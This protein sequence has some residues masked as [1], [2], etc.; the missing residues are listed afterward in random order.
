LL[1]NVREPLDINQVISHNVTAARLRAELTQEQLAQRCVERGLVWSRSVIAA[2]EAANRRLN[3][4]ELLIVAMSLDIATS[5]LLESDA[6]HVRIGSDEYPGR[7]IR[8]LLTSRPHMNWRSD[9]KATDVID[10][11]KRIGLGS[12][13]Q[14]AATR[15][16]IESAQVAELSR[17]LFG[18]G[19]GEGRDAQAPDGA[20]KQQRAAIT[21]RL[22]NQHLKPAAIEA[23]LIPEE[24]QQ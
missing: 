21:A 13:E 6:D 9:V 20:N 7:E 17:K 1:V 5:V 23:G 2:I 16:R 18:R 15:L 19:L 22:I 14:K 24:T 11:I 8:R 3:I 10:D 4:D 12:A